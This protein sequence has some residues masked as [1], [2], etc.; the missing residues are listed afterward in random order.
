M[1]INTFHNY[2]FIGI[3]GIGMSALALYFRSIG[4]N[5]AGY[6]HVS[7]DITEQLTRKGIDIHFNESV[8]AIPEPFK[9]PAET[10]V[11]FTPA[12]PDT[13][14]E[15]QYFKNNNFTIRKRSQVLG[16]ISKSS[17]NI[18][19]AGT[20]GKTT[21]SSMVAHI[22]KQSALD[23]SAFLGGIAKNY[24]SNLMLS[25]NV[26]NNVFSAD[27]PVVLE[28]DEYDRS[29]LALEPSMAAITAIDPDHLDIYGNYEELEK[30]FHEY[31]NCIRE[32]G[33]LVINK[34]IDNSIQTTKN[35][36]R[37]TY[38]I[39]QEADFVGDNIRNA[40]GQYSFDFK[41]KG[42][43]WI[44]GIKPGIPGRLNVENAT[45]ALALGYLA[46]VSPEELKS[47]IESFTGIQRRFDIQ[48][49]DG[50]KIFID[51]YAHHPEE[52]RRTIEAVRELYAGKKIT[53]I[54]QPH[55]YSRTRDFAPQFA[56]VLS[57]LDEIVLLDIYPAREK[58]I[59]G[60]TSEI[61]FN[62]INNTQKALISKKNIVEYIK[63]KQIEVL[64]TLGAGDIADIVPE[65][66]S[67]FEKQ[68]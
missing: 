12:V 25:N 23:C 52:L 68:T 34:K 47:G 39:E 51:D 5:V 57:K 17:K 36:N 41:I 14:A 48:Y 1:N 24:A 40:D 44:S 46:G 55:L 63:D 64:L 13:H 10:L 27:D 19:V 29:F 2:Y 61:I 16:L 22:L 31:V 65:I 67:L 15:Y 20:H 3:G 54:F 11:V 66:R 18:V 8:S 42:K 32:N 35:L 59:P 56:E 9:N 4:K 37:Y 60:V 53:G 21:I 50:N 45:C 28:G 6:D 26:Q 30:S 7:K 38:T 43:T 58:S 49:N 33:S 62:K